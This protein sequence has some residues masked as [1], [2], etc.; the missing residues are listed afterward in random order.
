MRKYLTLFSIVFALSFMVVSP[1]FAVKY[2]E[3]DGEEHPYV[4]LMF[5]H[6]VGP[7]GWRC[8]GTLISPRVFVTAGHCTDGAIFATVFFDSDVENGVANDAGFPWALGMEGT[9]FLYPEYIPEAFFVNDLGVVVLLDPYDL[10]EYADLPE[11][12]ELDAMKTK[13]GKQDTTFTA[14]GYGLQWINPVFISA[15]LVRMKARPKLN[16]INAPGLTGAFSLL[17]SNNHSTGGTCFGDSGGPN[18][19]GD[20]NVI[21]GVTSFGLNNNCAGTGGVFRLDKGPILEYLNNFVL[22]P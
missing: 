8:T 13:R 3:L 18:F 5:A 15:E 9:P 1:A 12:D 6:G 7:G 10:S 16:A 20:S 17:L 14:V 11:A 21:G 19:I 4:G 22:S 2:G